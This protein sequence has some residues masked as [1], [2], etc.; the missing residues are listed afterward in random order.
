ML[1]RMLVGDEDTLGEDMVNDGKM[2]GKVVHK[3]DFSE[4][5]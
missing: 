2:T 1:S 3:E 4:M 5:I